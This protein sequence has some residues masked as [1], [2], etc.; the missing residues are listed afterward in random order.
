MGT[1]DAARLGDLT[2]SMSNSNQPT[3][4]KAGHA[5]T[6]APIGPRPTCYASAAARG[7]AL[8]DAWL[9]QKQKEGS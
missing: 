3:N 8:V 4:A 7:E 1:S 6:R 2:S 5:L 9:R